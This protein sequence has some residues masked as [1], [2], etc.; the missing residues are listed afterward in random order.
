MA[1]AEL[2]PMAPDGATGSVESPGRDLRSGP[3]GTTPRLG[4]GAGAPRG[5]A[6]PGRAPARRTAPAPD[7]VQ[8]S[9][10]GRRLATTP[11][12]S[13]GGATAPAPR[14]YGARPGPAPS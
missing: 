12:L 3:H 11:R 7:R 6:D 4:L 13:R 8:R 10:T 2:R 5:G 9:V 1:D 14:L